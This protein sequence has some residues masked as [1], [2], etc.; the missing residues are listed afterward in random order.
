[1][2]TGL[3][4]A[5]GQLKGLQRRGPGLQLEISAPAE[6]LEG[7]RLGDSVAVDG[8]CLSVIA[9][10]E[11]EFRV[12]ASVESLSRSTLGQRRPGE[13]LHLERALKLGDRLGG[14]LVAGHIDGLGR[15]ER[16][17]PLGEALRLWFSLPS[18]L[19]RYL[20]EKGS[21]AIDGISLTI[22]D[23][24]PGRFS[25]VLIPHSQGVVQLHKKRPGS[26][27]NLEVDLLGKYVERLLGSR[28]QGSIDLE[29]LARCG[30]TD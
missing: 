3:V 30:F 19:E 24:K 8:A 25:V 13:L 2:F 28:A 12:E 14:H 1:M 11:R 18:G 20:V 6:L 16:S 4:E 17:E 7:M 10:T 15:L 26:Q 22:N 21:I 29:L 23:L 9:F 5:S 27:V